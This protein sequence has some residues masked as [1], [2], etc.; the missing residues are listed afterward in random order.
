MERIQAA[1]DKARARRA[2]QQRMSGA[3][4]GASLQ[5]V[6]VS[7]PAAREVVGTLV[8]HG[9]GLAE[10]EAAKTLHGR[11]LPLNQEVSAKPGP[12]KGKADRQ[13][14][15]EAL[16]T[17][18]PNQSRLERHR[19]VSFA[20]NPE[21]GT[22]DMMR[23]KIVQLMRTNGWRRVAITSPSAGCGKTTTCLN[24][25]FSLA[26]QSEQRA[27]V[28]DFDMR[29]PSMGKLL[30]LQGDRSFSK[31]LRG[32]SSLQEQ[33]MRTGANLA[34]GVNSAPT[35]NSSE[36]LHG[37]ACA[38]MLREMEEVYDPTILI[39]DTP[40]MMASD[41]FMAFAPNVDCAIL[42]AAAEMTT[43]DEIDRCEREIASVT[44][45]LGVVLNKCRY[46]DKGYGY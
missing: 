35:R 37:A 22:V 10:G 14:A 11:E 45:V 8:Q 44:N 36:I 20:N 24:L 33:L 15:W 27:I 41:D 46:T 21:S 30:G 28:V 40:P 43:V 17:F 26:R 42:L 2:A 1:L 13:A 9:R 34:F 5:D 12:S 23:T 39:F 16:T 4:V 32:E 19:V 38:T 6:D 18:H 29:R 3:S 31:V 25:A 7:E